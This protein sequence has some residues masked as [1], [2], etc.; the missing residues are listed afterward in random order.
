[1]G[2]VGG[3]ETLWS[4]MKPNPQTRYIVGA[5]IAAIVFHGLLMVAVNL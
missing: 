4:N 2:G 5:F 3:I 1:M